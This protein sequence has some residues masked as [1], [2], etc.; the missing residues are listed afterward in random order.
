M[1]GKGLQQGVTLGVSRNRVC[2]MS[3]SLASHLPE[4]MDIEQVEE[5]GIGAMRRAA[6][7]EHLIRTKSSNPQKEAVRRAEILQLTPLL[8]EVP[9]SSLRQL[10]SK[11]SEVNYM[12]GAYL[13][14]EGDTSDAMY[15][16]ES[17]RLG[18]YIEGRGKVTEIGAGDPVGELELI[19]KQARAASVR[20]E[21]K[22]ELLRLD[23]QAA[24]PV[25][26]KVWGG[27]Q[28]LERRTELLLKVPLFQSLP[29]NDLRVLVTRMTRVSY[30]EAGINIVTEGKMGDC[31][32]LIEEGSPMVWVQKV[33]RLRELNPKDYFGELAV[34]HHVPRTASVRTTGPTVCLRLRQAEV[35]RLLNSGAV[36]SASREILEKGFDAYGH[37]QQLRGSELIKQSTLRF[38]DLMVKLSTKLVAAR[39]EGSEG[40]GVVMKR[41][42]ASARWE[43]VR[44]ASGQGF[45]NREGYTA[46]HLCVSKVL[47]YPL[48]RK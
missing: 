3:L 30:S 21:S 13:F 38:W 40:S 15:I 26:H 17:G 36:A 47:Q 31:M 20:A 1:D 25:L 24:Q 16:V 2:E 44:R 42:S 32:Y 33:G 7:L 35:V 28:E 22:V 23:L 9:M 4:L 46:M 10:A 18:V 34:L 19:I 6:R 11:T 39:D 43:A 41:S 48:R 12:D 5:A 27:P 45:V 37:R 8:S 29:R 14:R